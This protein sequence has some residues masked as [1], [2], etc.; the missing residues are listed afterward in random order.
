M[1]AILGAGRPLT[2]GEED[3]KTKIPP[4]RNVILVSFSGIDGAGKSTQIKLLL[5]RLRVAGIAVRLFSFW[6][7]VAVLRRVRETSSHR[8][9]QSE[10]GIGSPERPVHRR[11]KNVRHW[12]MTPIRF[13]L[14]FLDALH[15]RR[16]VAGSL[17][18][19]AE[20]VIFDR[21]LHDQLANL[22]LNRKAA[23][24]YA[25]FLLE[26]VPH[27]VEARKRKPEYPLEFIHRNRASYLTVASLAG[28]MNVIEAL[29]VA[30]VHR[31]VM[32][33]VAKKLSSRQAAAMLQ[34]ASTSELPAEEQ[35][36]TGS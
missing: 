33:E 24:M 9:F 25:R 4:L 15:L 30:E 36:V 3:V 14:Y 34:P 18:S 19:E 2:S 35:T 27:P 32:Q 17:R 22:E 10:P 11:D 29:P 5:D 7:D 8:L 21:Y 23:R 1:G 16:V 20:V 6:D 13:L 28:S 12:F 26:L 31:L